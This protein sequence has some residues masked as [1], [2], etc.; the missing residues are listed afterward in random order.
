MF[1]SLYFCKYLM[2]IE[3]KYTKQRSI[4][5]KKLNDMKKCPNTANYFSHFQS[6]Y[7]RITI[8]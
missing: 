3:N 2:N 8:I 4:K 7:S 1:S 5:F 6:N